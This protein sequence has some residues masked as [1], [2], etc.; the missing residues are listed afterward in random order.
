MHAYRTKNQ[1]AFEEQRQTHIETLPNGLSVDTRPA[2]H[3]QHQHQYV[4]DSTRSA[5]PPAPNGGFTEPAD[6]YSAR[7]AMLS[8]RMRHSPT[9]HTGQRKSVSIAPGMRGSPDRQQLTRGSG[10]LARSAS[11]HGGIQASNDAANTTMSGHGEANPGLTRGL[12]SAGDSWSG[13]YMSPPSHKDRAR[14]Y[15]PENA[16]YTTPTTAHRPSMS[17]AISADHLRPGATLQMPP[18]PAA[19]EIGRSM[20]TPRGQHVRTRDGNAIARRN[21]HADFDSFHDR[22][23][24]SNNG[25][26]SQFNRSTHEDVASVSMHA[27]GR[28]AGQSFSGLGVRSMVEGNAMTPESPGF[29]LANAARSRHTRV[30]S[31]VSPTTRAQHLERTQNALSGGVRASRGLTVTTNAM[32]EFPSRHPMAGHSAGLVS[33]FPVR[34]TLS[35]TF[36]WGPQE[37]MRARTGSFAFSAN[38]RQSFQEPAARGNGA[39][40]EIS[41]HPHRASYAGS[42]QGSSAIGSGGNHQYQRTG[43]S[44][45]GGAARKA[46]HQSFQSKNSSGSQIRSNW[47]Y[48]DEMLSESDLKDQDFCSS[49]EED[50]GKDNVGDLVSQQKLIQKQQRE[51]FD[52]NLRCKMLTSAMS[53]KTQEPYE[54]LVNSYERTCAANR[55]ATREIEKLRGEKKL[56]EDENG[57]LAAERENPP[58]CTLPHGMTQEEVDQFNDL[59]DQ[60][61]QVQEQLKRV[62]TVSINR[63]SMVEDRDSRIRD[64]EEQL[65]QER[66]ESDDLLRRLK[67]LEMN[68]SAGVYQ[69]RARPQSAEQQQESPASESTSYRMR[70]GTVTTA[71]ETATLRAPSEISG[72]GMS[73]SK[74]MPEIGLGE[75]KELLSM[76]E[77]QKADIR[78]LKAELKRTSDLCSRYKEDLKEANKRA[79]TY[80]EQRRVAQSELKRSEATSRHAASNDS[81][82]VRMIDENESLKDEC[83]GLKRQL[84]DMR[85]QLDAQT[86]EA[87]A[88]LVNQ[89]DEQSDTED[90]SGS[91]TLRVENKRLSISLRN[92]ELRAETAESQRDS[93]VSA[94]N[95]MRCD[96][97]RFNHNSLRPFLRESTSD[98]AQSDK[99]R[100][101]L[102]Q[103]SQFK[104]VIPAVP[105]DTTPTKKG[106][107]RVSSLRIQRS[108]PRSNTVA[109]T[110]SPSLHSASD[111]AE[112]AQIPIDDDSFD[113]GSSPRGY[114]PRYSSDRRSVPVYSFEHD[115][116]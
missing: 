96:W 105:E 110:L 64:L 63:Q 19:S 74:N 49:D 45:V 73:A 50:F 101:T 46:K 76:L 28:S 10:A 42:I 8:P 41:R 40:A 92:A 24:M 66:N 75:K 54:A 67:E 48:K 39:A 53:S 30:N 69:T 4:E 106:R 98:S 83:D 89:I 80:E 82:L 7:S 26:E 71:S 5:Y 6:G 29:S 3:G 52:L 115:R 72:A 94:L 14:H 23:M 107:H 62:E 109:T 27:L 36:A 57:Q 79:H 13:A 85:N 44:H 17:T 20:T 77:S 15:Q 56:L 34:D 35:D 99:V 95:Q 37:A 78:V 114:S 43:S 51:I 86:D 65:S 112:D 60:F 91:A 16:V 70:A 104:L 9:H 116:I 97:D 2:N 103:W 87:I 22:S 59:Q 93:A 25:Y 84:D 47:H 108:R 38:A 81:E 111:P 31:L 55:R 113:M 11:A 68:I 102:N 88:V 1:G 18:P 100:D 58:P 32:S 61:V 21:S 90:D 33:E 12:M